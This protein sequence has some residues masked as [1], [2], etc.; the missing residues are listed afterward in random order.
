MTEAILLYVL[1][2]G[3]NT[4]TKDIS[5]GDQAPKIQLGMLGIYIMFFVLIGL[6]CLYKYK[7]KLP[8]LKAAYDI[9]QG[10]KRFTFTEDPANM[11]KYDKQSAKEIFVNSDQITK[12]LIEK[13]ERE[14][15]ETP[16]KAPK[17]TITNKWAGKIFGT[18]GSVGDS[19]FKKTQGI[20]DNLNKPSTDSESLLDVGQKVVNIIPGAQ[21]SGKAISS[22]ITN[23]MS[24]VKTGWNEIK[25]EQRDKNKK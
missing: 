17:Q 13:S 15:N 16:E 7:V 21:T 4:I 5:G 25:S 10:Y 9:T 1:I 20:L 6:W 19:I 23:V 12:D 18:M 2:S 22:G 14:K 3:Y 24:T 8:V 11:N